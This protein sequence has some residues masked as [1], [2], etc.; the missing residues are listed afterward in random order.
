M[1]SNLTAAT[2]LENLNEKRNKDV[3]VTTEKEQGRVLFCYGQHLSMAVSG[4]ES[5]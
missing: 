1:L 2:L 4:A 3:S 5:A